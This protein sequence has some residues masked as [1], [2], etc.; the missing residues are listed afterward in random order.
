M[1]AFF[2]IMLLSYLFEFSQCFTLPSFA[3]FKAYVWAMMVNNGNKCMTN[4]AAVCFFLGRNI[5]SFQRFLSD[6]QWEIPAVARKLVEILIAK[7]GDQLSIYGALLGCID[8]TLVAKTSKKMVAIQRWHQHSGNADQLS[9][10]IGHHW[11]I[12]GLILRHPIRSICLPILTRLI[13]GNQNQ[14]LWI[15]GPNGTRPADFWDCVIALVIELKTYLPTTLKL[16][17]VADAYFSKAPFIKPLVEQGIHLISRL[18][19]DAIGW[20]QLAPEPPLTRKRGRP[21]TKGT[22]WKLADLLKLPRQPVEVMLYGKL[23][24]LQIV[25]RDV[26]LRDIKELI[27][28]VVIETATKPLLLMAT[29][30]SL[31]AEQIIEIY[32]SRYSIELTIRDLKQHCGF[33]DYQCYST[34][35]FLRS[36]FLSCVSFCLWMLFMVENT[37]PIRLPNRQIFSLRISVELFSL[38]TIS[39]KIRLPADYFSKV[40]RSCGL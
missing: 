8:T 7:L 36:V 11:G 14:Q 15:N 29:D 24:T 27:R 6:N 3:Y 38:K 23:E 13:A 39:E 19:K 5:T 4:I 20:D 33:G 25:V 2:P 12:I 22:M 28:V 21:K 16:R 30:L 35:A 26:Y 18:R 9:S 40:R 37:D 32:G 34:I 17:I 31:S 1:N 10:I